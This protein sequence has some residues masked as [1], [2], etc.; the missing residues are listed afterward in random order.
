MPVLS[1]WQIGEGTVFYLGFNDELQE[2]SWN[3]FH[4]LPEYPVFW[5]KLIEWLGG[6]GDISD[7]NLETGTVS[8]LSKTEDIQTPS[9][10]LTANR[11][12]FD[13]VGVYNIAGKKIAVNLY[14]DRESDTTVDA[15]EL[16]Q[17]AVADDEPKLVRADTYTAKKDIS[18]YLIGVLFLLLLLEIFIVR[19]R[20][21]L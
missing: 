8:S 5:I 9:R 4:N 7:Y 15:S 2:G 12:L 18:N 19:G 13:E 11:V 6:V 14:D 1:Y 10:T 21:E 17:R 20:G 3:N 16:I